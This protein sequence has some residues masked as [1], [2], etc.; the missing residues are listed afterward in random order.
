MGVTL[1]RV[2]LKFFT[3]GCG[4]GGLWRENPRERE[5]HNRAGWGD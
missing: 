1:R 3:L 4:K 2:E 5:F